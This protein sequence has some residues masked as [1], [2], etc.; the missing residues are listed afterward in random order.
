[1]ER[2][3][4]VSPFTFKNTNNGYSLSADGL[5]ADKLRYY[6]VY[7]DK[8]AVADSN[9]FSSPVSGEAALLKDM[10][11]VQEVT[12]RVSLSGTIGSDAMLQ[13]HLAALATATQN[14]T[15][16]S[17]DQWTIHQ[18]GESLVIPSQ[19]SE[20]L[21]TVDIE[22]NNCLPVP[23]QDIS[24]DKILSFKRQRAD[25]LLA[26]RLCL[27]DLYLEISKSQDI[28]RAKNT[29]IQKLEVAIRDLNTVTKESWLSSVF[30]S[31][32]VSIDQGLRI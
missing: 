15:A 25:E 24:L 18:F 6:L 26:L 16:Q 5:S 29:A 8:I 30:A 4:V 27:D 14:L 21:A 7:W 20:Q 10:G 28:P 13:I 22:L 17:P 32:T 2:G 23:S 9:I 31:R 1:M 12:G 19:Y 3:I 11:I